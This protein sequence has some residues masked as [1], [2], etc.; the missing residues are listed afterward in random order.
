MIDCLGS[1]LDDDGA[2]E[3]VVRVLVEPEQGQGDDGV[4]P[5]QEQGGGEEAD[6]QRRKVP[7]NKRPSLRS[8]VSG[9]FI[10][11]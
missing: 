7:Q 8:R 1:L 6:R 4:H 10:T 3:P 2:D 11:H 5:E 9:E